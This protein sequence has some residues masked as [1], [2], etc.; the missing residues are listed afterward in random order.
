MGLA[1]YSPKGYEYE[2]AEDDA[3][4][5]EDPSPQSPEK[6][7]SSMSCSSLM[8]KWV[9]RNMRKE[10][11]EYV[12]YRYISWHMSV[13]STEESDS[14]KGR[15]SFTNRPSCLDSAKSPHYTIFL[16]PNHY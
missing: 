4:K 7:I 8:S 15:T 5:F 12:L 14:G 1:I 16:V 13:Y 9:L 3:P 10:T 2:A 6:P 11:K